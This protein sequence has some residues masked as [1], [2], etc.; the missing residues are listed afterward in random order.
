MLFIYFFGIFATAVIF[1]TLLKKNWKMLSYIFLVGMVIISCFRYGQGTDYFAYK[2]YFE[3]CSNHML[4]ALEDTTAHMNIGYR[5]LTSLFKI[6]NLNYEVFIVIFSI[7]IL[8]MYFKTIKK[9]SK[10]SL[11][12][13]FILFSLYYQVYV[14]SALRQGL[15]MS[16]FFYA[17]FA[18]FLNYKNKR[19]ILFIFIAGLFHGSVLD[20]KSVV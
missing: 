14:N 3:N 1:Q 6:M 7:F 16:I 9:Y 19:Y 4:V 10:N 5:G 11:L 15:A 20:R 18:Y 2:K 8:F 13:I 17:F 12:S